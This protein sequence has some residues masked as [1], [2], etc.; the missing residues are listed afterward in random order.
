MLEGAINFLGR[1]WGNLF[2]SWR[3]NIEIKLCTDFMTPLVSII[4]NVYMSSFIPVTT[5]VVPLA[6]DS[7]TA[8]SAPRGMCIEFW[9]W[10]IP[11]SSLEK[12]TAT[13]SSVLAWRIPG[14][15][16]PG[17]LPSMGSRRVGHDWSNL[18]AA[19][20]SLVG[21]DSL[22]EGMATYS[23]VLPWETPWTEESGR[24]QSVRL[25]RIRYNLATKP[26]LPLLG[27]PWVLFPGIPKTDASG[28]KT[29][30]S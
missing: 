28:T 2:H 27:C 9:L 21:E 18:A 1:T 14:T 12:E 16:E 7:L 8:G 17:G 4:E 22:G 26:P 15:G 19:V 20:S 6:A 29:A 5:I 10:R 13:H 23:S 11:V 24:L 3:K 25:Q 30:E